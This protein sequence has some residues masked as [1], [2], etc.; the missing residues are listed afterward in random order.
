MAI[1]FDNDGRPAYM[2][3]Q[4]ATSTDGVWYAIAGKMDTS[5]AYEFTAAQ[6]FLNT[7]EID[8]Y[9]TMNYGFNN[10]LNPAARDAAL[11]TPVRGT[12]CFVRQDAGGSALNQIQFY[13]GSTWQ[14]G[15][16][17]TAVSAGTGITVT[18]GTGP[19]P[20]IA[21]SSNVVLLT[22]T[23]TLTNKTISGSS[24]TL[25]NI[26]NGS[27]TNSSI[28]INGSSVSLGGSVTVTGESFSPFMLMGA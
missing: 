20:S 1:T 4:G 22:E 21:V 11:A 16:D 19:N 9:V 7:V 6:T 12:I 5:I 3:K 10:F 24:N 27:L 23:Q 15:G 18:N 17:I 8:D 13:D 28:T 14:A 25:T 2:F 26:A